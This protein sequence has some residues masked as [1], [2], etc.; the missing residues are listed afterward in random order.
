MK[1]FIRCLLEVGAPG[2]V[3]ESLKSSMRKSGNLII[4]SHNFVGVQ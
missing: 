4:D 2:W 1:N 3:V